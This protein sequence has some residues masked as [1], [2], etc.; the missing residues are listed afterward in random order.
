MTFSVVIVSLNG[1]Q[2]IAMPLDALAASDPRPHEVI[3]VDNGSSDG[4]SDFVVANYPW[5]TLVRAP[6]NLGFAGGNNLGIVN[7]V[8]DVVVLLNDDT[9]PRANW[10]APIRDAFAAN[11]RLGIAGCSLL[12]PGGEKIQHQGGVIHANGLTDH[13]EWNAQWSGED[14]LPA[15]IDA[16]YVTGAAMAIRRSVIDRVGMLDAGYWPIYFEEVDFC[17]RATRAGFG[18]AVVPRS[19]VI[20]HESQT[21]VRFSAKFL[22]TYHRNRIRFLLKNRRVR[23]WMAALGAEVRWIVQHRPWDQL[24]PCALAYAWAPVHVAD[25]LRQRWSGRR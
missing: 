9:E 5:V 19:V 1:R 2:R 6:R 17:E 21:T 10:L 11:R 12:Y 3:V 20:H 18:C 25:V 24:W 14:S 23:G 15:H 16:P 8:G 22:K 4:L 13:A 7:A